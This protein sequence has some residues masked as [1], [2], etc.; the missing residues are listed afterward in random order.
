[1]TTG[2]QFR[3]QTRA[4]SPLY[5]LALRVVILTAPAVSMD[6][7]LLMERAGASALATGLPEAALDPADLDTLL[8]DL[9]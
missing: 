9:R 2:S 6:R 3:A 7:A 4:L 5:R 8:R 1:M